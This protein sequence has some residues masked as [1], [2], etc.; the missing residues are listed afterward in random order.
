M[1]FLTVFIYF[2]G[3][4]QGFMDTTLF[5]LL[6]LAV[7]LGILLVISSLLGIILDLTL[8]L[9][10]KKIRYLNRIFLHIFFMIFGGSMSLVGSFINIISQGLFI[11]ELF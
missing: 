6:E 1:C 11:E 4:I 8:L 3:T 2:L 10:I 9:S 7:V 5:M